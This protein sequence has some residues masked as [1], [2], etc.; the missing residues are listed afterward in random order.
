[1]T[2]KDISNGPDW[3]LWVILVV[4]AVISVV[5]LTGHGAN[6]IAG[7]NTASKEEQNRYDTRKLCRVVGAGMSVITV[8]ILIMTVWESTLPASFAKV[9]LAVSGIDSIVMIILA[10]TICKK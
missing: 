5:L 7:Y 4:F 9:F 3:I 6:L 10:N 1:M 2:L 8:M